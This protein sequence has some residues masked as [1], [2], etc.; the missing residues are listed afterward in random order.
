MTHIRNRTNKPVSAA[1]AAILLSAG[2]GTSA[3]A[4]ETSQS[5]WQGELHDA[6]VDGKVETSFALNRYLN[7][8]AINTDVSDGVVVLSGTV[9]SEIDRDLAGE[10]ARSIDGVTEVKNRLEI[11]K[12]DDKKDKNDAP[13]LGERVDDATT[14]ARVKYALLASDSTAGFDIDVDVERGTVTLS[15]EVESSQERQLAE[16]IAGN[17]EGVKEV[18]NHLEI[19]KQS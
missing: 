12:T 6:W 15:G 8:F 2:L 13:T 14:A 5:E 19:A 4:G 11:A 9:E 1:I 17:A 3:L 7:P 18:V 16:R 10:I